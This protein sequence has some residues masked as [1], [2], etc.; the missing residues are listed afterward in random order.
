MR[1][2]LPFLSAASNVLLK[3][4]S[5]LRRKV[6][7]VK[8]ARLSLPLTEVMK[9]ARLT[10]ALLD[11]PRQSLPRPRLRHGERP[12]LLVDQK[13]VHSLFRSIAGFPSSS[14]SSPNFPNCSF[15]RESALV[16]TAYLRSYFSV[17]QTKTLRSTA[18]GYLSELRHA[19]CPEKSHSFFCS[20]FSPTELLA[21]ASN[22]SSSTATGQDK[23]AYPM[24]K[25]FPPSGKDF[26]LLHIFNLSWTLH[27]FPF[28][29]KTS[30][31]IP[32]HKLSTL[33]LPSGLSLS[34]PAYQSCLNVSFY[35]V[36]T[37]FWNLI[38]FFLPAKSVS[39][40]DG[41]H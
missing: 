15:L 7:L 3:P 23:V 13:S 24:L 12:S 35:P 40:L 33:L 41:P 34:P 18:R 22:L 21:A 25:H 5:L 8:N 30:S 36:C 10:S 14:S 19:T 4:G 1:P 37:S 31:I 20:S 28:I 17:S 16:Y 2:N 39:A 11:A 38:P 9:I 32:I 29:W 6:W 27:F 26:L